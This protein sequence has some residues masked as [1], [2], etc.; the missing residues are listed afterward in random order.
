MSSAQAAVRPAMTLFLKE[1]TDVGAQLS[2]YVT[3][4]VAD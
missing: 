1:R 4:G 3:P 2:V